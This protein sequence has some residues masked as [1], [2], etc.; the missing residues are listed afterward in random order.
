MNELAGEGTQTRQEL[1]WAIYVRI[2]S[3]GNVRVPIVANEVNPCGCGDASR[4]H[5]INDPV[6]RDDGVLLDILHGKEWMPTRTMRPS[7]T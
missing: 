7:K 4:L 2:D 3:R 1:S 6:K 5:C